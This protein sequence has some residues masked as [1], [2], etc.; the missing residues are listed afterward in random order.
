MRRAATPMT[1]I[2][3]VLRLSQ[4]HSSMVLWCWTFIFSL[5][6]A[7]Y[8]LRPIR[9]EMGSAGGVDKLAWLFT[10]TLLAMLALNPLFGW[11][12]RRLPREKFIPLSY[13]FFSLNLVAFATLLQFGPT[14]WHIWIGRAFF[15]WTS[16]FN[17][18]VVSVFWSYAAD[19]FSKAQGK[20]LF[21]LLATGAT[22][23][24]MLGSWLT[25]HLIASIDRNGLLMLSVLF[26]QLSI[27]SFYRVSRK[28]AIDTS[29]VQPPRDI[30]G[31]SALAGMH[32][33]L[34]SQYLA[35]I[36]CFIVLNSIITTLIYFHQARMAHLEWTD[37]TSRTAFFASIN[38]SINSATLLL[39]LLL[40]GRMMKRLG[41]GITLSTLPLLSILGC[42]ALA[43]QPSATTLTW[44]QVMRRASNFA[45]AKPAREVLFTTLEREDRYKAKN[46]IDTVIYRAG[47]QIGSWL[48]AGMTRLGTP[49]HA[50]LFFAAAL[51]IFWF[52]LALWLGKRQEV[53]GLPPQPAGSA[54]PEGLQ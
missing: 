12:V 40:T 39:Q 9:D 34:Q 44:V 18:F 48:Y 42:T 33:V 50:I 36:S 27:F 38:F 46:F 24:G 11:L 8:L 47:D 45:F 5:F 25:T 21:G 17:L 13:Q 2:A 22:L 37:A 29:K 26:L 30:I 14:D 19:T 7:Y 54:H 28:I 4:P 53:M 16:V 1:R 43:L 20:R 6:V 52:T 49:I 35:G 51:S 32:R 31:G 23:G 41:V 3:R 10:G 15:I